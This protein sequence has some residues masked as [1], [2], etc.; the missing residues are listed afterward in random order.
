MQTLQLRPNPGYH[1]DCCRLSALLCS[2][3][4]DLKLNLLFSEEAL[5]RA[6]GQVSASCHVSIILALF[7]SSRIEIGSDSKEENMT[8]SRGLWGTAL[9][10]ALFMVRLAPAFEGGDK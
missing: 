7:R 9:L 10:T 2:K 1:P 6:Q 5:G 3:E 8:R 4:V